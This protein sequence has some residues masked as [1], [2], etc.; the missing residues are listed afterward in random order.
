MLTRCALLLNLLMPTGV[1]TADATSGSQT[2]SASQ[3]QLVKYAHAGQFLMHF[4][5]WQQKL[6]KRL[7]VAT[8]VDRTLAALHV[9]TTF[10][11]Y[12]Q[13][14][15]DIVTYVARRLK[16]LLRANE[17]RSDVDVLS[18]WSTALHNDAQGATDKLQQVCI[19]PAISV[20]LLRV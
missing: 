20:L 16:R 19:P 4:A 10:Y 8:T 18:E 14:R 2:G 3:K 6:L 12:N 17:Q 7:H 1:T 9:W 5:E 11:F 15:I 13:P